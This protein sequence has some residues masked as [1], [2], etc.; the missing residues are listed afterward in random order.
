MT[1]QSLGVQEAGQRI[2][3]D[4]SLGILWNRRERT[5]AGVSMDARAKMTMREFH[6]V[7]EMVS[8]PYLELLTCQ[9]RLGWTVFGNEDIQPE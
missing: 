5:L 9:S 4:G 3:R 7:A 6:E 8:G 2:A 1:R